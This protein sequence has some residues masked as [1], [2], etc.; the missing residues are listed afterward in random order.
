MC[1][2]LDANQAGDVANSRDFAHINEFIRWM[3]RGGKIEVG[4]RLTV[5][6]SKLAQFRRLMVQWER[7]GQI[8]IVSQS[9]LETE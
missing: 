8:A 7:R 3:T 4:G 9:D 5:E 2:V 6:L 1:A